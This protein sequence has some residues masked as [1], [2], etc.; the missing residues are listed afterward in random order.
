MFV[1]CNFSLTYEDMIVDYFNR[2]PAEMDALLFEHKYA[3]SEINDWW[4]N[5]LINQRKT[6]NVKP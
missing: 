6:K 4:L 2:S 1:R 5:H 3:K